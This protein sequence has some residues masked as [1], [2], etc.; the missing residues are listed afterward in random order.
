[1][2]ADRTSI[3]IV[4]YVHGQLCIILQILICFAGNVKFLV[5][6]AASTV[7]MQQPAESSVAYVP[8]LS[9]ALSKYPDGNFILLPNNRTHT[10]RYGWTKQQ[11]CLSSAPTI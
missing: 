2:E 10:S 5:R 1:M 4:D 9:T 11:T 6:Q 8:T 7:D 3:Y